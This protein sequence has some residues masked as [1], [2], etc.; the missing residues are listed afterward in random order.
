MDFYTLMNDGQHRVQMSKSC[1]SP[2]HD[3]QRNVILDVMRQTLAD[4]IVHKVAVKER[5]SDY[6]TEFHM[7]LV[8]FKPE[9]FARI[10]SDCAREYDMNKRS[11]NDVFGD[12]SDKLRKEN[13]K[14]KGIMRKLV[15]HTQNGELAMVVTGNAAVEAA[16]EYVEMMKA[17][18]L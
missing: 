13:E 3:A 12:P 8:M 7:D 14:L 17:G 4:H 1:M 9:E 11:M 16:R 18:D 2:V 6:S 15:S 10:V 5:K